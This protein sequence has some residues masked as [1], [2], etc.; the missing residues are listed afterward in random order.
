MKVKESSKTQTK[1]SLEFIKLE[2]KIKKNM[3]H[4]FTINKYST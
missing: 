3:F 4:L 2:Q 1:N